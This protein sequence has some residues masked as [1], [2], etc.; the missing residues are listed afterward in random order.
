MSCDRRHYIWHFTASPS[1]ISTDIQTFPRLINTLYTVLYSECA[2]PYAVQYDGINSQTVTTLRTQTVEDWNF[3]CV[4]VWVCMCVSMCGCKHIERDTEREKE[5]RENEKR[6]NSLKWTK[7]TTIP[8][9]LVRV[10]LKFMVEI[11]GWKEK[12]LEMATS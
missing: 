8:H 2:S 4:S 9:G 3:M 10:K 7:M 12:E 6:G 11:L 1:E 5:K